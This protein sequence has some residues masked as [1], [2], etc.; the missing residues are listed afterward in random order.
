MIQNLIKILLAILFLLCLVDM[1]YGYFQLVRFLGMTGF[2]LLAFQEKNKVLYAT[3]I[4]SAI[5]INPFFKI[6]LGRTVWNIVDVIWSIVLISTII[7]THLSNRKT[8][9]SRQQKYLQKQGWSYA[10]FSFP[11]S[12]ETVSLLNSKTI[13]K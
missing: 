3:W 12:F 6:P 5:L 13:E 9:S 4:A 2:C 8:Q 11:L 10:V 7:M 1:P